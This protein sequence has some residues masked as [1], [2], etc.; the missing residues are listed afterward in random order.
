MSKIGK[1][2]MPA[3]EEVSNKSSIFM[4]HILTVSCLNGFYGSTIS[5]QP[6]LELEACYEN[7]IWTD[8][9]MASHRLNQAIMKPICLAVLT[10]IQLGIIYYIY[11][12]C[13]YKRETTQL[14]QSGDSIL[15]SLNLVDTVNSAPSQ[16]FEVVEQIPNKAISDTLKKQL[17]EKESLYDIFD[18]PFVG[19]II[20]NDNANDK[21][22]EVKEYTFGESLASSKDIW[23]K[24]KTVTDSIFPKTITGHD[25][26]LG[27]GRYKHYFVPDKVTTDE[28]KESFKNKILSK[29]QTNVSET[30]QS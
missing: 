17:E 12:L 5:G 2:W 27:P 8:Q 3:S 15:N 4:V 30:N 21:L 24:R 7:A 14:I 13:V 16:S 20:N 26:N 25:E 22:A 28:I 19:D 11:T 9:M 18:G 29:R 1:H 10:V 23:L 6:I